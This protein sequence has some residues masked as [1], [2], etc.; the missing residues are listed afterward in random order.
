[1]SENAETSFEE[2]MEE[3]KTSDPIHHDLLVAF[4]QYSQ[5]SKMQA[6]AIGAIVDL[7]SMSRA[8]EKKND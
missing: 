7:I 3:L 5:A 1:M 4:S 2:R 8:Q 6:Q